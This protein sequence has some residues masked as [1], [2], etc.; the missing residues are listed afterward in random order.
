VPG[1][2]VTQAQLDSFGLVAPP[3]PVPAVI[4]FA[5]DEDT[6]QPKRTWPDYERCVSG[7]RHPQRKTRPRQAEIE[8][9]GIFALT[10]EN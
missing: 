2:I 6:Q 10:A 9:L 4:E 7:A 3:E 5:L 8:A 1:R